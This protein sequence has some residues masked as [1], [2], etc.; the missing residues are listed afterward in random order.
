MDSSRCASRSGRW[1]YVEVWVSKRRVRSVGR[2]RR[3]G[4]SGTRWL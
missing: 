4:D 1:G 2:R 3:G